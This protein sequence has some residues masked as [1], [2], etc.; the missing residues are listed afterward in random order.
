[1]FH[2][3][4][5]AETPSD[6][7]NGALRV[8]STSPYNLLIA[9]IPKNYDDSHNQQQLLPFIDATGSFFNDSNTIFK[10][11]SSFVWRVHNN[12]IF[13]STPTTPVNGWRTE[14][15]GSSYTQYPAKDNILEYELTTDEAFRGRNKIFIASDDVCYCPI[16][17]YPLRCVTDVDPNSI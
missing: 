15:C 8:C 7:P 10:R 14:W 9:D 6:T 2:Y 3:S 1:M 13:S 12:D 5:D 16:S 17:G 11:R 4:G